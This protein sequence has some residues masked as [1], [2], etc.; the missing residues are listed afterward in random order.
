MIAAIDINYRSPRGLPPFGLGLAHLVEVA[1]GVL[2]Q[3]IQPL[4]EDPSF[5]RLTTSARRWRERAFASVG[6]P[7]KAMPRRR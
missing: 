7:A 3:E 6:L 1:L 4:V 5:T 2:G